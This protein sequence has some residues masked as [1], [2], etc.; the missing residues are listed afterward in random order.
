MEDAAQ[1][2]RAAT[3]PAFAHRCRDGPC[4]RAVGVRRPAPADLST[5]V[6]HRSGIRTEKLLTFETPLLRY[7][8]FDKRVAFVN[9]ELEKVRAIPGVTHAG[10]ITEF[11]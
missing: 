2:A 10:A 9:A 5:P 6:E 3:V 1:P 4:G 7:K 8:D 11:R